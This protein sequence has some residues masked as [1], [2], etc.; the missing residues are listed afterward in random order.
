MGHSLAER[1]NAGPTN[2]ERVTAGESITGDLMT[3]VL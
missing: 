1:A 2:V 3:K